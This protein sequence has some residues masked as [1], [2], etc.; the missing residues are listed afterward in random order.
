MSL[1]LFQF[2][3]ASGLKH[4]KNTT[5]DKTFAL[6]VHSVLLLLACQTPCENITIYTIVTMFLEVKKREKKKIRE[7]DIRI[8][9][10]RADLYTLFLCVREP[11]WLCQAVHTM[12]HPL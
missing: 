6:Q 10:G 3:A 12:K 8:K 11:R 7:G 2:T 4:D 9:N 5:G 1:C